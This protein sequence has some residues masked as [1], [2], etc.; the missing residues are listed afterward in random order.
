MNLMWEETRLKGYTSE[1]KYLRRIVSEDDD[2][3]K[4][5]GEFKYLG[6]IVN[7]EDDDTPAMY[8][9]LLTREQHASRRRGHGTLL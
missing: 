4:R 3:I 5:V 8:K 7:E 2:E 9:R 6:R 1:F